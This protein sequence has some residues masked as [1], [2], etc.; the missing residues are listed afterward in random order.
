MSIGTGVVIAISFQQIDSAPY[1]ERAAESY[2]EGL[3]STDCRVE[4]IHIF[5]FPAVK[6]AFLKFKCVDS[7]GDRAMDFRLCAD[8]WSQILTT[9]GFTSHFH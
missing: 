5:T 8:W 1:A 4:E 3:E 2:N 9:C 7:S 6:A